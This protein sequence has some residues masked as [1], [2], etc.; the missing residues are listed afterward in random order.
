MD[1]TLTA[2][3]IG[4]IGALCGSL[5]TAAATYFSVDYTKKLER[6]RQSLL[7]C[8]RNI[9]AFYDL[10]RRYTEALAQPG[11]T[12][13]TWKRDIRKQQ[14]ADDRLTPDLTELDANNQITRLSS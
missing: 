4:A 12:A 8:W 6:D 5:I 14:R 2:G 13:E 10:E 11:K 1:D 9:S 7:K 3:L